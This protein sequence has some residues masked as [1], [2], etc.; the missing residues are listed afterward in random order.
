MSDLNRNFTY[1]TE[2]ELI[3]A[4]FQAHQQRIV[5]HGIVRQKFGILL[6]SCI[7]YYFG[8]WSNV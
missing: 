2:D 8:M 3:G 5:H 6:D 1:Y 4:W 7:Q